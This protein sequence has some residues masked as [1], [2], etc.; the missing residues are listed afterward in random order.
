MCR[1]LFAIVLGVSAFIAVGRAVETEPAT[2]KE[3]ITRWKKAAGVGSSLPDGVFSIV[4][5]STQDGIPGD[6][7]E[8][9]SFDKFHLMVKREFDES[10]IVL[11]F[12]TKA[13]R[14]WNGFI[15]RLEDDELKRATTLAYL[16][17]ALFLGPDAGAQVMEV[18]KQ[19][20]SGDYSLIVLPEGGKP[21]TWYIDA[22][23]SLPLR[24]VFEGL[25]SQ[26]MTTYSDWGT[27]AGIKTPRVG[28]VTETNKPDYEWK[29]RSAE[30]LS[31]GSDQ[32]F[33]APKA[34]PSDATLTPD[35]PPIPFRMEADHI[36]F[37]VAVNGR[38]PLGFILDTGDDQ[39]VINTPYLSDF[40]LA[41]YA[42]SETTGGGNSTEYVY[43]SGA[44]FTWP[45]VELRRQ[46]VAAV[47]QT[48]LERALGVKLGGLL[49]YDFISRFIVEIDYGKRLITL[50]DPKSWSYAGNGFQIPITFDEGVPFTK[51]TIT[52]KSKR[53]I[54]AYFVIDF[55]AMETMTITS[56]FARSNDL[57]AVAPNDS[58][59]NK[60]A[61]LEKQFFAQQ[62]VRG[63]I[64]QL[65]LGDLVIDSIPV[66]MS[67]N[68]T[69]AYASSSFS[70]T[71]G[72]GIFKRYHVFLDYAHERIILEPTPAATAPF[73]ER[74][75]YGL[76]ILASGPD[77]HTYGVSSVRPGSPAEKDGFLKGDI[78]S[79][80][81][82]R[83]SRDFTLGQLREALAHEDKSYRV[84]V[85]RQGADKEFQIE[86]RLVS[87]ER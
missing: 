77:L 82:G 30:Y 25:D 18:S 22:K 20:T 12:S 40:G 55:G 56:P 14:D 29:R 2:A 54:P 23:S 78:V 86:V 62:N 79:T 49:G 15:R 69:G 7:H 58:N 71:I 74:R 68:T 10:E 35:A 9:L 46:H 1:K 19:S 27:L 47:D 17:R 33:E 3:L 44:T 66:N 80:L 57:Y 16:E 50:H 76:A 73:P 39:E 52:M 84:R 48:G 83:D 70:G 42:R 4:T 21:V 36:V 32:Q 6:E 59:V 43:A 63:K 65:R 38:A 11:T 13:R 26:V 61:G 41:V 37:D 85:R 75:T 24:S 5:T 45:G 51:A 87:I 67:V 81:D 53:D 28:K 8:V 31:K 72:E 34:G 64:D 60:P